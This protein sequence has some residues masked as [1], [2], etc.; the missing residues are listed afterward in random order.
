MTI[1]QLTHLKESEDK[2]E[3]KEAKNNFPFDGGSH[4]EQS[5]RRKCFLGYVVALSNEGGGMLVFGMTDK[6]PR[7]VVGSDFALGL[8]GNL[9]DEVYKRLYIRVHCEE[10]LDESGNRILITHIPTRPPARL[11]KYEGVAL[12]R[13]GDSLR[14]M[15]DDE[16][17][18]ILSEQ[19]PDFSA[20]ICA[21]FTLDKIDDDAFVTLKEKYAFKQKNKAF[22]HAT[23][24]HALIDLGLMIDG[25]LTYAAL[26]LLGKQEVLKKLLPNAL[27]NIEYR[28]NENQIPFDKRYSILNP[29]FKGIDEIWETIQLRNND[30][31]INQAAYIFD[32]PFF[33]EEVIREAILNAIAHRD[34][35]I[36]SEIVIKQSPESLRVLNPG[37]FPK[38]V[39]LDNLIRINSTPR[40]RLLTEILEKTG[41]VERSGQGVDKIYRITLSEGKTEPDYTK[42][43]LFQVELYLNGKVEDKAFNIFIKNFYDKLQNDDLLGPHDIIGLFNIKENK[44]DKVDKDIIQKLEDFQLIKK[45]GGIASNKY[46]LNDEYYELKNSKSEVA[47]FRINDLLIVYSVVSENGI[48]KMGDFVKAFDNDLTRDQVRYLIEQLTDRALTKYG[49]G[50]TTEYSFSKE[51]KSLDNLIKHLED[52]Q[53]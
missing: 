2:V 11:M 6:E 14:N 46:V 48:A 50:R 27:V 53:V 21:D 13:T 16:M 5:D 10:L 47:G 40:S 33:N 38:G 1:E 9:E 24:E 4:K 29:L 15:S 36:S 44:S 49:E 17:F 34:Y 7:N 39:T 18:K 52:N 3:F 41:L 51:F 30:N 37:G 23:K 31:K 20:K 26:I 42:S 43:D 19:E 35:T 45:S 22:I 32:V 25:R 8:I 12:M 28:N